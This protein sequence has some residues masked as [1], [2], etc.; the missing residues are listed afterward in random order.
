MQRYEQF[1]DVLKTDSGTR[2]YSTL[3]Y[4]KIER[5]TSDIYI[6]TKASDRLDLLAYEY[7]ADSRYWVLLARANRLNNA[8]LKPPAGFRLRIPF[9][10]NTGDIEQIF[11]D[12]QF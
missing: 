8:T 6:I 10:L 4:P 12:A 9:P 2:R 5:K 1:C 7:Y 3:Y 11:K